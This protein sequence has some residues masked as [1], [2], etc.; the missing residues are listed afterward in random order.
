LSLTEQ[1]SETLHAVWQATQAR[2]AEILAT[3]SDEDRAAVER[4]MSALR[5]AMVTSGN[6]FEQ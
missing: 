2:L 1:G 3:L 6:I 5:A 4:A